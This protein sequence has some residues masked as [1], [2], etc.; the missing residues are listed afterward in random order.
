M[1]DLVGM[2]LNQHYIEYR[3]LDG[4]MSLA[5]RD[6]AVKEFNTDPEVELRYFIYFLKLLDEILPVYLRH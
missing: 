5:S 6:R 4:S 1:L 3:R 2:A